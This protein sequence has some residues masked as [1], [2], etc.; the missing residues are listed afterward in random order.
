[1]KRRGAETQSTEENFLTGQVIGACIEV[2]RCLGPGLLESVYEEA[3]CYEL[4]RR[5]IRFVRQRSVPIRYKGIALSGAYRLDLLVE[6]R[7]IV[8]IKAV[9]QLLPIHSVQLLTYLKLTGC[10][11][12]L[13]VN[14]NVAALKHGIR[15]IAHTNPQSSF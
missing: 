1:M 15:R 12:G 4:S 5:C 3:L 2:H 6:D 11:F 8:E 14:F 13:L 9:E 10:A 7:I